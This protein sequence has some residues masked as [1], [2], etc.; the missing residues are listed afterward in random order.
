MR[1]FIFEG[2]ATSGKSTLIQQ[3][4]ASLSSLYIV[5]V[6]EA[7]THIPIMK[8]TENSHIDFFTNLVSEKLSSNADLVIFDPTTI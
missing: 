8:E 6:D 4:K 5:V 3:L 7:E 2:I 1:V